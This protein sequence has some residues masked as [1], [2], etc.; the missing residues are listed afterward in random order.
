MKWVC[1]IAMLVMVLSIGFAGYQVT[2]VP[3]DQVEMWREKWAALAPQ[4]PD[5]GNGAAWNFEVEYD[6]EDFVP[7]SVTGEDPASG[8]SALSVEPDEEPRGGFAQ[9]QRYDIDID[10]QEGLD[11]T[12]RKQEGLDDA[13]KKVKAVF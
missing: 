13:K 9:K 11:D 12:Q 3:K 4:A 7:M 5:G 8:G 2:V 10:T 6:E 1:L